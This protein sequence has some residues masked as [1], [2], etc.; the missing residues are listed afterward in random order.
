MHSV[1]KCYS[2]IIISNSLVMYLWSGA[3]GLPGVHGLHSK[4]CTRKT[5][6]WPK[7]KNVCGRTWLKCW[8]WR[9]TLR[10]WVE[11]ETVKHNNQN[12]SDTVNVTW[13]S[14]LCFNRLPHLQKSAMTLPCSTTKWHWEKCSKLSTSMWVRKSILVFSK[15]D[16]Y[17]YTSSPSVYSVVNKNNRKAG[18]YRLLWGLD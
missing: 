14:A 5:R 17:F 6:T 10:T 9:Q 7:M 1:P 3:R 13:V 4:D 8:S 2:V 16:F 12:V 15:E 18:R 11:L